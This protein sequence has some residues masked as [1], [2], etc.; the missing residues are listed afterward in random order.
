MTDTTF[1]IL[2]TN[3]F[4]SSVLTFEDI[5]CVI[6]VLDCIYWVAFLMFCSSEVDKKANMQRA[7]NI[8]FFVADTGVDSMFSVGRI[9]KSGKI[10]TIWITEHILDVG[11]DS[12]VWIQARLT[13]HIEILKVK[14]S[15]AFTYTYC[16]LCVEITVFGGVLICTFV[17]Q[18][19]QISDCLKLFSRSCFIFSL[20]PFS[21]LIFQKSVF[22]WFEYFFPRKFPQII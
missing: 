7:C 13:E 9:V 20:I 21:I 8:H 11:G 14:L 3:L 10:R 16:R 22:L 1:V 15:L 17:A 4:F 12:V 18:A 5:T 6:V 19:L 2:I